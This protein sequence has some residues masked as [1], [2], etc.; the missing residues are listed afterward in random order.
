MVGLTR[1][2][3]ALAVALGTAAIAAL[4]GSL[5][6]TLGAESQRLLQSPG[7]VIGSVLVFAVFLWA[8]WR[9]AKRKL[10]EP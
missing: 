6:L 3:T 10:R 7:F 2:M 9:V 4:F 1:P 5:A 8:A